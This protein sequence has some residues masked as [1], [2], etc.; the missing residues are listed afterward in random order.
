[1]V[2]NDN[3]YMSFMYDN[4]V[5]LE[6]LRYNP[7]W[8]KILYYEPSMLSEFKKEAQ[9]RLKIR[10]VDKLDNFSNKLKLFSSLGSYFN[11]K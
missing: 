2:L 7:R 5:Y 8:Y 9:E 1:M 10:A 11:K 3:S 6:Y 4:P